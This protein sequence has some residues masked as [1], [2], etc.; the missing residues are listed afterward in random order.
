LYLHFCLLI[1]IG[2]IVSLFVFVYIIIVII[3]EK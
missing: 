3:W 1:L 2:F